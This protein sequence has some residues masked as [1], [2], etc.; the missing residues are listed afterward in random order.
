M[1]KGIK[2]IR[3]WAMARV[4]AIAPT[5]WPDRAFQCIDDGTSRRPRLED[6]DQVRGFEVDYLDGRL[7][8][9][10]QDLLPCG[11]TGHYMTAELTIRVRYPGQGRRSEVLDVMGTDA[12]QIGGA[13]LDPFEWDFTNTGIY[14]VE[15]LEPDQPV[16]IR[17][18]EF[19]EAAGT[20]S[21]AADV[22]GRIAATNIRIQYEED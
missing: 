13:L 17:A 7:P 18:L 10:R 3:A 2:N 20:A 6:W 1:A 5:L 22:V 11:R 16:D 8:W 9:P 15:V 4:K 12:S 14:D 21:H 19:D